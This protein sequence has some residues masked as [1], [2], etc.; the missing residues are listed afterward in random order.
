MGVLEQVVQCFSSDLVQL[1]VAAEI[2]DPVHYQLSLDPAPAFNR[3]QSYRSASTGRF[4][5][6]QAGEAQK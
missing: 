2:F 6:R 1:L 3:F 4:L 5:L